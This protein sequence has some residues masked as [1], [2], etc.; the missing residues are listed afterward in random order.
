MKKNMSKL[1]GGIRIAVA[2]V[3]VALYFAGIIPGLVATVLLAV[4]A[5]FILTGIFRFCPLYWPFGAS[6]CKTD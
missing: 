6:T 1:D 5:I 3:I 4:A 2:I